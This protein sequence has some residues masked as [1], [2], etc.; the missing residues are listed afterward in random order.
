MRAHAGEQGMRLNG[1]LR[2]KRDDQLAAPIL[3]GGNNLPSSTIGTDRKPGHC[4]T[5]RKPCVF[6]LMLALEFRIPRA[7]G[8]HEPGIDGR[9]VYV[10]PDEFLS[11]AF[12]PTGEGKFPSAV[13]E[14]MGN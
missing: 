14:Q 8:A 6:V 10:V 11:Q 3:A 4:T 13:R 9:D 5:E 2:R 1:D 12:R 7:A